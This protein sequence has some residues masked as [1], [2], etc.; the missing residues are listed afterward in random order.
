MFNGN[1]QN[2]KYKTKTKKKRGAQPQNAK[3]SGNMVTLCGCS[4]SEI[5]TATTTATNEHTLSAIT[6]PTYYIG[7][8]YTHEQRPISLAQNHKTISMVITL[9][10][11]FRIPTFLIIGANLHDIFAIFPFHTNTI[12]FFGFLPSGF[13]RKHTH[14]TISL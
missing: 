14:D 11:A 4:L 7:L 1:K 6:I 10:A 2:T 12:K 9:C 5:K 8:N 3:Y 13:A